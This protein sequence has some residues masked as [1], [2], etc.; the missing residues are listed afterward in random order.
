V[1]IR[2]ELEAHISRCLSRLEKDG[3]SDD[4]MDTNRWITSHFVK[5]CEAKPHSEI[6]FDTIAEFLKCQYDI[7]VKG[8]LCASQISVR[9]PLLILWE[10]SQTVPRHDKIGV[11][12]T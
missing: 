1:I 8:K 7:E 4:V 2:S 3:H 11:N 12:D 6:T 10:Y 5:Y 9:R